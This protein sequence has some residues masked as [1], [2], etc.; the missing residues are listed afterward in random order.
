MANIED[1]MLSLDIGYHAGAEAMRV[2]TEVVDRL[3]ND[4]SKTAATAIA[5][6]YIQFKLEGLKEIMGEK[7]PFFNHVIED[8]NKSL[9]ATGHIDE[10][11]KEMEKKI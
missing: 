10:F 9:R 3:P 7:N 8:V 6:G 5:F 2:L 1:M 11:K 4:A